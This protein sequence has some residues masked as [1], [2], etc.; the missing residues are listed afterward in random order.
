MPIA[1]S[2]LNLHCRSREPEPNSDMTNLEPETTL[3]ESVLQHF[4]GLFYRLTK[5]DC[6]ISWK[7]KQIYFDFFHS[8]KKSHRQR[9]DNKKIVNS[10]CVRSLSY[11]TV[12]YSCLKLKNIYNKQKPI[13]NQYFFL[14]Q[15]VY[16][17]LKFELYSTTY[18][19]AFFVNFN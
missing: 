5:Y 11:R 10:V 14:Q 4:N 18:L 8:F 16:S 15:I 6:I 12:C 7:N 17:I 1:C 9:K 2:N 19:H 3:E 13:K